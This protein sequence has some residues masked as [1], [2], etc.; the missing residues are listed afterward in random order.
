MLVLEYLPGGSLADLLRTPEFHPSLRRAIV[1]ALD[2]AKAM[3][4]LH[5]HM[6]ASP[7]SSD[8]CRH[9][10]LNEVVG[11]TDA[12]APRHRHGPG[13]GQSHDPLARP[14]VRPCFILDHKRKNSN[15]LSQESVA[16]AFRCPGPGL[17]RSHD[18]PAS[19]HMG[20]LRPF[21]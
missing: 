14:H 18:Q 4:Y 12:A 1:M 20:S 16:R 19:P 2:C 17:R 3:T 11:K 13:T 10:L 8:N 21:P 9:R 15:L 5:A 6:Y 7:R